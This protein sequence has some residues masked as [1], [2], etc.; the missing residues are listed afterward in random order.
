[1]SDLVPKLRTT[2]RRARSL[3]TGQGHRL[4][5]FYTERSDK[6]GES[7]GA[8]CYK[9]GCDQTAIVALIRKTGELIIQGS[10]VRERCTGRE[11]EK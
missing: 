5:P 8:W 3:A 7:A 11:Q 2:K 10:A 1:M 4:S 9:L 6:D